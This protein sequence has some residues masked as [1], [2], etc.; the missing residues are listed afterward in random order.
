MDIVGAKASKDLASHRSVHME[1]GLEWN[2][3]IHIHAKTIARL[4][5]LIPESHS[6][7]ETHT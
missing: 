3:I 7:H 2:G 4:L 5:N 1:D 6:T